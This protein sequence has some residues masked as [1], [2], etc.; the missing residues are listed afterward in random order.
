MN[1]AVAAVENP[2]TAIGF[3]SAAAEKPEH[4]GTVLIA[5]L[6]LFVLAALPILLVKVLPL[7]NYPNHLARIF[8]IA[9]EGRDPLLSKFYGV[10][11]KIIPNLAMDLLAPPLA[12]IAGIFWAG[13]IFV[14]AILALMASG[15]QAV[16]VA[17]HRRLSLGPA[18]A[19]LFVYNEI[20]SLGEL[21][22]LF[23]VGLALWGFAAWIGLRRSSPVLRL[24][25]SLGFVVA[26]FTCHLAAVG[27][28]GLA[29][30][31]F[32]AWRLLPA[33]KTAGAE[34][35]WL[36]RIGVLVLPFLAVLALLAAGPT[37]KFASTGLHWELY[38]KAQGLWFILKTYNSAHD[39]VFG[40]LVAIGII[41]AW[42]RRL[43]RL[44][45]AG[46]IFIACAAPLF[47]AVPESVMSATHVD[48]RLPIAFLFVLLSLVVWDF[49]GSRRQRVFIVGL[50][51]IG[52]W[53]IAD[54][55][56]AYGRMNDTVAQ[57]E[58]SELLIPPGSKILVA[59]A[60]AGGAY[61]KLNLRTLAA[62][63]MVEVSGKTDRAYFG[64]AN[65]FCEAMILRSSL[66]SVVFAHHAQQVL[67]VKAPYDSIARVDDIDDLTVPELIEPSL[68]TARSP[69][70]RIYW[71]T[72]L[73]D[74][75]FLYVAGGAAAANPAPD[76]LGLLDSSGDFQLYTIN[77]A[78]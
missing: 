32:E 26:L 12:W 49:S 7:D 33:A 23:G 77:R 63:M 35:S 59:T 70:S 48:S 40:V 14:L 13:K 38:S 34:E 47:L 17:L 3:R 28:Y 73:Q 51:V 42:R 72:W 46:W 15:V 56:V 4:A 53:R 2:A 62:D 10:D 29:I 9:Q 44:H 76:R 60:D 18:V 21:N 65:L 68:R 50:A 25:V 66:V 31:S 41:W 43:F 67:V 11:W 6:A 74:Y 57:L 16:H 20:L 45:P 64:M 19:I 75:D 8:V 36:L 24:L 71:A 5:S 54:V 30:F 39:L 61:S 37:A 78:P 52:M 69:Q 1:D 58:Q 22:Y 55:A 27:V